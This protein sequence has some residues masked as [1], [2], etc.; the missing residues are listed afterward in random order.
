MI[1]SI[2]DYGIDDM[3]AD[4]PEEEIK[5]EL[6]QMRAMDYKKDELRQMRAMDYRRMN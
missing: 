1:R 5:D 6:R 3:Q 2:N 4:D